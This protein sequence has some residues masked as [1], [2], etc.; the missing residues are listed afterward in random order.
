M[1]TDEM[2]AFETVYFNWLEERISPTP[3]QPELDEKAQQ[4]MN[5]LTHNH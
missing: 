5:L 2:A 4:I 1:N 3:R